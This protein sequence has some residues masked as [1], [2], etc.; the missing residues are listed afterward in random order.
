MLLVF[1]TRALSGVLENN[2]GRGRVSVQGVLQQ[3]A[4]AFVLP[5][6]SLKI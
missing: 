2:S 5:V 6:K 4:L 1:H 3:T